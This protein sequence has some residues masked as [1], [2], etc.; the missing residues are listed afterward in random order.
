MAHKSL[1]LIRILIGIHSTDAEFRTSVQNDWFP[2]APSDV[3]D[4]IL[5]FY[6]SNVTLG[7][8]FGTGEANAVNPEYKRV[9]VRTA[10]ISIIDK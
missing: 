2:E 8:P 5:D 7:S 9:S 3:I 4:Q 10:H 1:G 6:P